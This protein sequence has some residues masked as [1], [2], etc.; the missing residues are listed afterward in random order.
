MHWRSST[1]AGEVLSLPV[2]P[3]MAL[4]QSAKASITL[5]ECVM[6]G[7]VIGLCWNCTVLERRLLWVCLMW[8][9]CV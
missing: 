4:M 9:L 2:M 3:W 8:Q 6:E 1:V 7:L 5:S